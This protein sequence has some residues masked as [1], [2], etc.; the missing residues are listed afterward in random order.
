MSALAHHWE[1]KLLALGFAVL[2]WLFVMISEKSDLIVSAPLEFDGI[3]P[4]LAL[5][6]KGPDSV[7]VQLHALRGRLARLTPDQVKA[8]INL[9]GAAAGEVAVRVLPEHVAVPSGVTVIRVNPSRIRVVLEGAPSRSEA[10]SRD[11]SR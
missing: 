9:S 6:A 2:L 1:L 5:E 11:P 4:G 8:R 7:D 10:V 3:P